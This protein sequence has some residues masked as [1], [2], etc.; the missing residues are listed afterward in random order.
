MLE[1]IIDFISEYEQI[2]K[3]SINAD[4]DFFKDLEMSSVDLMQMYCQ[5]EEEYG[6]EMENE[7]IFKFQTVGDVAEYIKLKT[8]E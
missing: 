1:K 4:S 8:E 5:L 6:I 3:D 2:D 7:D